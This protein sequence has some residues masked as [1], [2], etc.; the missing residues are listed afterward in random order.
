M[1][2]CLATTPSRSLNASIPLPVAFAP[3]DDK[4]RRELLQRVGR[5]IPGGGHVLREHGMVEG[6]SPREERGGQ[7]DADAIR[8]PA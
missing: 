4:I 5:D 1:L 6:L 3:W 8:I 2:A 7:G